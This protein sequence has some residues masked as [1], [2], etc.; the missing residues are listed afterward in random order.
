MADNFR[1][2]PDWDDI[3]VFLALSRHHS[4]SGAAR[5]L[6]VNHA[7]VA[8][9][10]ASLEQAMGMKLVDRRPDGYVPTPT[11]LRA[12]AVAADMDAAAAQLSRLDRGDGD[13]PAGLVRI[14][15]TPS[16]AQHF[17]VQHLTTLIT[18]HPGL[19]IEI[20]TDIRS[21]SLERR[22]TDIALRLS[23]PDDGDVLAT[24]LLTLGFGFYA[25]QIWSARIVEGEAPVLIGFDESNA[26]LPEA[27]WL[28]RQFPHARVA[29]RADTQ[30]G[31]AIAAAGGAGIALL[32][33]FIGRMDHRLNICA[34]GKEPPPRAVW[35]VMRRHYRKHI[36]IAAA[37]DFLR[38]LFESQRTLFEPAR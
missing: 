23:R 13:G 22:E 29:F 36:A 6:G 1:T 9:R 12:L 5:A 21:V 38:R 17:L 37:A 35:L 3:R 25:S 24:R 28:T 7:T 34:L 32:P 18:D 10:I 33:H 16:L 26:Q 2:G 30:S 8:R 15:A 19:D 31:Q 11:G 20:G 4:L 14:N 27:I